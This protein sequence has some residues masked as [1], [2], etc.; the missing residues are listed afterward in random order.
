MAFNVMMTAGAQSRSLIQGF[1]EKV[2][3]SKKKLRLFVPGR[4]WALAR[5]LAMCL[6]FP[7]EANLPDSLDACRTSRLGPGERRAAL[8]EVGDTHRYVA[9]AREKMANDVS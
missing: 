6:C 5:S 4:R 7:G 2:E 9:L 1:R 8:H 3:D